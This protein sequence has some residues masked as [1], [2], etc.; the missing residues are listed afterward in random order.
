M[1]DEILDEIWRV[2]E[3]LIKKFGGFDGFWKHVQKVDRAHRQRQRRK[4]TAKPRK[5]K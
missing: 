1:A 5:Q 3:M 4:R 2:R